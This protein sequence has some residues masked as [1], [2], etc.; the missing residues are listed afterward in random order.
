MTILENA[1]KRIKKCSYL[2]GSTV[3]IDPKR[4]PDSFAF[5]M[6]YT[7]LCLAVKRGETTWEEIEQSLCPSKKDIV[8]VHKEY[9]KVLRAKLSK[10]VKKAK[11]KIKKGKK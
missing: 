9:R 11:K 3:M 10:K 8:N 6:A 4:D 5:Q 1:I 2:R 7:Q